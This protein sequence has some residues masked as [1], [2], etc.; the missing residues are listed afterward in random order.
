M[1]TK[2]PPRKITPE[3]TSEGRLFTAVAVLAMLVISAF[4]ITHPTAFASSAWN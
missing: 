2:L 3:S 1:P 4:L